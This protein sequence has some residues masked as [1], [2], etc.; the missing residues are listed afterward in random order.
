MVK[1]SPGIA[2]MDDAYCYCQHYCQRKQFA[3]GT[4]S[5]KQGKRNKHKH[6][7]RKTTK[8]IVTR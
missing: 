1:R 6:D 5:S 4:T 3:P 8:K 2:T 7:K